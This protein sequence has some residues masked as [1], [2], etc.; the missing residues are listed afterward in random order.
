MTDINEGFQELPAYAARATS[1]YKIV[2]NHVGVA[3]RALIVHS[4]VGPQNVPIRFRADGIVIFEFNKCESYSGGAVEPYEVPEGGLVPNSAQLA[5]TARDAIRERRF[6]YMTAFLTCFNIALNRTNRLFV[7]SSSDHHIWARF[8]NG[9]WKMMD[10]ATGGLNDFQ[11]YFGTINAT[12]L[13]KAIAAFCSIRGDKVEESLQALDLF[14]RTA[15]H[16]SNH[17]FQTVL[18]LGWALIEACQNTIWEHYVCG[19]Y[20]ATNPHSNI[21]GAR[22]K[23]LRTDRNFTASIKG[24]ILALAGKFSDNDLEHIDKVRRK[25]NSFMHGLSTVTQSDAF[26]TMFACRVVAR[27]AFGLELMPFGNS[28]GWDYTR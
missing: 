23:H 10:N 6:R 24:Q 22:L 1:S 17:E 16:N 26:D 19:G 13:N 11:G 9:Q 2:M 20:K 4:G 12:T 14:Y 3:E 18:I 28:G 8:E 7:P 5:I 15:F 25:R 27:M 21:T